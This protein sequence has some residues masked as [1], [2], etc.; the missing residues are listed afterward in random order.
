MPP[1]FQ[2]GLEA[3]NLLI[4]P[5]FELT[6]ACKYLDCME[7]L[8]LGCNIGYKEIVS[9]LSDCITSSKVYRDSSNDRLAVR[10]QSYFEVMDVS[11]ACHQ[12]VFLSW[13][14][15][16]FGCATV[17]LAAVSLVLKNSLSSFIKICEK[18]VSNVQSSKKFL[19]KLCSILNKYN[20]PLLLFFASDVNFS[21][22]KNIVSLKWLSA[23]RKALKKNLFEKFDGKLRHQQRRKKQEVPTLTKY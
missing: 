23:K 9:V 2:D 17:A 10:M 5:A 6:Q 20:L 1:P 11:E 18:L 3:A 22:E 7:S 14:F 21:L 16:K 12:T 8:P 19:E 15:E 4:Q 13:K